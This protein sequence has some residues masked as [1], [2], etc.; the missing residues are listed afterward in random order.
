MLYNSP[1][2]DIIYSGW[3]LAR[4]NRDMTE[5]LLFDLMSYEIKYRREFKRIRFVYLIDVLTYKK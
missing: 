3:L 4:E 5:N 2:M 1:E